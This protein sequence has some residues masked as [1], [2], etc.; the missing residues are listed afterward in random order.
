MTFQMTIFPALDG[1]C[2]LLS[3][4]VRPDL[5]HLLVDLGRAQTYE[6]IKDEL[7]SIGELELLVVSHIDADHISGAMPLVQEKEPPVRPKRVWFNGHE[8]LVAA[9]TRNP[10]YE[11]YSARQGDK[12][13]KGIVRFGWPWNEEF[14]GEI[15]STDSPEADG[16]L[17]VGGLTLRLLSPADKDLVALL[18]YWNSELKTTNMRPSDPDEEQAPV[19]GA[20]YESFSAVIDVKQLARPDRYVAD[21]TKTNG[22]SI[23]FLAEF[24]GKRVL[25][26]ADAHSETLE[27]SIRPLAEKEGGRFRLDLM[28]VSHHGSMANCSPSLLTLLDCTRFAFSTDGSRSHKHPNRETIARILFADP[29]REKTLY[30]NYR[31]EQTEIWQ[32]HALPSIWNFNCVFPGSDGTDST[33]GTL[34]IPV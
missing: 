4:G 11:P 26:A 18:P 6:A 27:E 32:R 25:L 5:R 21:K 8:Q 9:K 19:I 1:D 13:S 31:Q 14:A 2:I 33:N 30:F 7:K 24:E 10:L 15:V 20:Q 23:A 17:D 29:K 12:L 28:K 16:P 34:R 22:S 3:W